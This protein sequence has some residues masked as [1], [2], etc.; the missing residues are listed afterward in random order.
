MVQIAKSHIFQLIEEFD[1][2]LLTLR[3][4][5]VYD[6]LRTRDIAEISIFFF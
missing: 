3:Y 6:Y 1:M 2:P 5:G 4:R